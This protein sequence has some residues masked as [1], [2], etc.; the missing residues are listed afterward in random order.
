MTHSK[1]FLLATTLAAVAAF[2]VA[3]G[4]TTTV[5]TSADAAGGSGTA[6]AADAPAKIGSSITLSGM[7]DLQMKVTVLK[8]DQQVASSNEYITPDAGNRYVGVKL[9]LENVGKTAYNDSP[10]NGAALVDT[11]DQSFDADYAE[12]ATPALGSPKIAPGDTRV[13]WITFQVPKKAKL[14]KFQMTL[15]SG[16]ADQTGEWMVGK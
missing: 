7:E 3:C 15:D 4:G 9:K 12:V 13:G 14:K 8:V 16:F 6:S 11:K 1:R 5:N 2:S 10:T